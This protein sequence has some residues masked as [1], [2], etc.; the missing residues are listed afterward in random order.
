MNHK[1]IPEFAVLGHPNEGKSSVV[2]TLTEDDSVIISPTPGETRKCRSFPVFIDGKEVICFT[3]TP[4]FQV[5][6]KSLEWFRNYSGPINE[7]VQQFILENRNQ[8][9][10]RDECELFAPIARGAGII[11]VADGSR[12]ARRDDRAEMEIL[13]LTAKP[14]MAII[15]SKDTHSDYSE[16][17]KNEFRKNFNIIRI[18]NA[19]NATYKER[20]SLLS[21]L[22]GI[23]QEWEASLEDVI[24]AFKM[25]WDHRIHLTAGLI[26]VLL[27]ICLTHKATRTISGNL[28]E[29]EEKTRLRNVYKEELLAVEKKTHEKIR[30]LFKHNIFHVE[31]PPHSILTQ[32]LFSQKTWQMLG[33]TKGQLVA[34]GA[35][36]GGAAGV[37][38]DIATV[39]HSLGLFAAVGSAFG[40]GSALFGSQQM[41]KAKVVGLP[42]GGYRI[43]VGPNQNI[44]FMYILLDRALL[45]YSQVIHWTHG[46]R[47][48]PEIHTDMLNAKNKKQGFTA[49][50][51]DEIKQTC[52]LFFREMQKKDTDRQE[53]AKQ[54]MQGI[55]KSFLDQQR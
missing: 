40:A 25:D 27:A 47:G 54:K 16:E 7:I 3:D 26:T 37:M 6:Q 45:Y 44:Q 19:H 8:K 32:D 28:L 22:K 42:V 31:F 11:Y 38:I 49:L 43:T 46:K 51:T 36:F 34:A 20:I 48:Y 5:P 24:T 23:D 17:W 15:N 9:D 14:R 30:K 10:Y 13:R 2:S 52:N 50:F 4:G 55:I 33:L 29:K 1:L 53:I 35:A 18:F 39:G 41:E 12:P 21:S